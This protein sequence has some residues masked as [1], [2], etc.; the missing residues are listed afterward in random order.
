MLEF[1]LMPHAARFLVAA[2]AVLLASLAAWS[3]DAPPQPAGSA[4]LPVEA[5]EERVAYYLDQCAAALEEADAFG[6]EQK[7]SLRRAANTLVVC[8]A[9]VAL[10]DGDSAQKPHAAATV[11][12]AQQLARAY[13]DHAAATEA[14]AAARAAW[15]DGGE[16]TEV[17]WE[18]MASLGA[19]MNE[20]NV[21][22]ARVRR[23]VSNER[24]LTRRGE[25]ALGDVATLAMIANA[26]IYD[27]HEVKDDEQL[28]FWYEL[29]AAFRDQA[30]E[31][32]GAVEAKDFEAAQEALSGM[33][34]ACDECHSEFEVEA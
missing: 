20:V 30:T 6:D 27:T 19:M 9:T 12:A 17:A 26:S 28:P 33:Q 29:M 18:R 4:W 25:R 21:V 14:L 8:A 15:T 1:L 5:A 11:A 16:A 13:G 24:N 22:N 23:A 3:A 7:E 32:R 34:N 2:S 31:L 10:H